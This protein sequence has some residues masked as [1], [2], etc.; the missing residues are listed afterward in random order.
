[1]DPVK[2]E[3]E[4]L[5]LFEDDHRLLQLRVDDHER[6]IDDL[7]SHLKALT[8]AFYLGQLRESPQA[9]EH[10]AK[11]PM[12]DMESMSEDL[13]LKALIRGL[14]A[15]VGGEKFDPEAAEVSSG[16][17]LL[18]NHDTCILQ[19]DFDAMS[20][21]WS[22]LAAPLED[23]SN[24]WVAQCLDLYTEITHKSDSIARRE[25]EKASSFHRAQLVEVRMRLMA[26]QLREEM[27]QLKEDRMLIGVLCT[28][29]L[30]QIGYR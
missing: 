24:A 9:R 25:D 20:T 3:Q 15:H 10:A 26:A 16:T 11:N 18:C 6:S 22:I 27:S 4:A 7:E 30:K 2:D 19:E 1:M 14:R 12:D 13:K 29:F 23:R 28:E 17:F 5:N 21:R 8:E